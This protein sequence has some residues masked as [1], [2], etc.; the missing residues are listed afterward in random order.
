LSIGIGARMI[1]YADQICRDRTETLFAFR[2]TRN[3]IAD[4][5]GIADATID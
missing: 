3:R 4:I 2:Q 5:A 1:L